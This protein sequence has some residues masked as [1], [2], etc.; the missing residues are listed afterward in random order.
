MAKRISLIVCVLFT[1][2]GVVFAATIQKSDDTAR[3][4]GN[5]SAT[6]PYNNVPVTILSI[7]DAGGY[8]NYVLLPQGAAPAGTGHFA[9]A[10][11]T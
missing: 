9:A 8:K 4:Y 2:S 3:F 7:H 6:F 5:W 11:G 1:F 10:N